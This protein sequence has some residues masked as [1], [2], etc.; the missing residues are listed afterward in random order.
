MMVE[1]CGKAFPAGHFR[2]F[3]NEGDV[4]AAHWSF[5]DWMIGSG[6]PRT[7][8]AVSICDGEYYE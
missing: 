3:G 5:L 2:Q 6:R 7:T 8:F 1:M 4:D